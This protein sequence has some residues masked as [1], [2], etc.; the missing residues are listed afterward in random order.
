MVKRRLNLRIT[1][2]RFNKLSLYAA[3]RDMTMTAILEELI[4]SID[5]GKIDKNLAALNSSSTN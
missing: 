2:R 4:D 5:E 1:E 3:T